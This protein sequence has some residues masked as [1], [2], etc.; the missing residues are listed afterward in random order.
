M[1]SK[2]SASE[3]EAQ[4][5]KKGQTP[6]LQRPI[7]SLL[8]LLGKRWMLRV[9]WELREGEAFTFRVLQERCGG[10]SSSVLSARLG[11]LRDAGIVERAGG[12]YR[13]SASGR[14]LEEPLL[15]L[16]AWANRRM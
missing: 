6:I 1:R 2:P 4:V 5:K 16:N 13:L 11:E 7:V 14:A 15:A 9:L 3:S 10:L 8:D 12:G